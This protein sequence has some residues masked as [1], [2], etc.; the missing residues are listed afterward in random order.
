[1]QKRNRSQDIY[2]NWHYDQPMRPPQDIPRLVLKATEPGCLGYLAIFATWLIGVAVSI[3]FWVAIVIL[4][5]WAAK[6]VGLL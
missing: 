6:E 2:G 4:G 5:I 1:M 3:A